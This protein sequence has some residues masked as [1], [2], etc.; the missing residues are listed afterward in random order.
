[1]EGVIEHKFVGT[2]LWNHVSIKVSVREGAV[3]GRQLTGKLDRVVRGRSVSMKV[4]N[5]IRN[6]I[7]PLTLSYASET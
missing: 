7:I 2:D 3:R 1:M 5:D 6:S 4:K